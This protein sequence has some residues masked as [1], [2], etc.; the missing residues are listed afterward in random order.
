MYIRL[1]EHFYSNTLLLENQFVFRKD[2]AP[3][4]AIF[5]LTDEILNTLNNKTTASSI[6]CDLEKA[7]NSVNHNL[8][9][10]KLPYHGI[11]VKAKLLL[12]S[13]AYWTVHHLDI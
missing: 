12:K 4:D 6:F 7:F 2:I 8:L 5:T 1:N 3:E 10:Y 13:Y 9:L 11:S